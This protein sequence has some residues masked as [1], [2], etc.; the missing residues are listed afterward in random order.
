M[1]RGVLW[2]FVVRRLVGALFVLWGVVTLTF[3]LL[4][5]TPGDFTNTI[6]DF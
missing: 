5:L 4:N 3:I 1:N 6:P 2:V